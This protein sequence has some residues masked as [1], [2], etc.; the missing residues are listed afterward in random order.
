MKTMLTLAAALI[1]SGCAS[2]LEPQ[3]QMH[4]YNGCVDSWMEVRD[5][6]NNILISYLGE[7]GLEPLPITGSAG[8]EMKLTARAFSTTNNRPLGVATTTI[9]VPTEYWSTSTGSGMSKDRSAQLGTW[10]INYLSTQLDR[11]YSCSG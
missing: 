9:S 10:E 2:F 5:G 6:R 8:G 3:L 1:L 7:G 4:A 11:N